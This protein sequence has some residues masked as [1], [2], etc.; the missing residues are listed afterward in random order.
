MEKKPLIIWQKWIDPFGNDEDESKW[1]DYDNDLP[2]DSTLSDVAESPLPHS[3]KTIKVIASPM[4]LIPYSEHTAASKIFNFW[5]GH[6]NF[7]LSK[8]I[9]DAIEVIGGVETL[10]IFTRYRF[11]V[12]I[13]KCFDDSAVMNTINNHLY[14]IVKLYDKQ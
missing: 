4:G 1:V 3:K 13:G 8:D 5:T 14:K 12:G 2:S 11:R 10:D 7:D 9:S 6:T